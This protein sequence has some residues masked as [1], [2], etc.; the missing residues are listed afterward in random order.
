MISTHLSVTDA[1]RARDHRKHETH[2]RA[3]RF[4]FLG[5]KLGKPKGTYLDDLVQLK[6]AIVLCELCWRQFDRMAKRVHYFHENRIPVG[7]KCDSCR[8]F[9]PAGHLFMPEQHLFTR[10][11]GS[12]VPYL[13]FP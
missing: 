7:G 8:S 5:R 13:Q 3:K 2:R 11:Q 9:D 10:G 4:Q 6:K 12:W 1:K